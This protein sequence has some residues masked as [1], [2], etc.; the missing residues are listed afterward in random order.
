[1][2]H[3]TI[4][5]ALMVGGMEV[6]QPAAA[7]V[8][9]GLSPRINLVLMNTFQRRQGDAPP[10]PPGCAATCS[11]VGNTVASV[12]GST[13]SNFRCYLYLRRQISCGRLRLQVALPLYVARNLSNCHSSIV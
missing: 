1:M 6:M 7:V 3:F 9:A 2:I 12:S 5:F 13:T 10:V 8:L 11:P 4:I